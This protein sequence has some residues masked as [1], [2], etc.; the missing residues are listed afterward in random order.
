MIKN[1]NGNIPNG[2][3]VRHGCGYH[4]DLMDFLASGAKTAEVDVPHGA[5]CEGIYSGLRTARNRDKS[6]KDKIA[7]IRR[8]GR[9][10]LERLDAD[11]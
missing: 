9:V 4:K 2:A 1:L 6:I 11:S 7:V 5:K 10:F 8:G 3:N